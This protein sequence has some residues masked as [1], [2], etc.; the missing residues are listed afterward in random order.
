MDKITVGK[1]IA[2]QRKQLSLTQK[3]FAEQLG[4]TDKAVSRWETGKGYPDIETIE[5]IA[6]IFNVTINDVLS[7]KINKPEEKET[8]AEILL[9]AKGFQDVVVSINEGAVDVVV[10]TAELTDIQRAQIEDI[11]KRKTE[12]GAENI[13]I[14]TVSN[15]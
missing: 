1:F 2:E 15:Q 6:K 4:V 13:I 10:N 7:G 5:E 3:Q 12:I 8:A 9:Q 14:S 11:V